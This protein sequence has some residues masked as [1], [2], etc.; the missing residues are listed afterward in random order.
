MTILHRVN[1]EGP[2][3]VTADVRHEGACDKVLR[4]AIQVDCLRAPVLGAILR[5]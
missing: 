1:K 4:R 5:I 2:E 3:G